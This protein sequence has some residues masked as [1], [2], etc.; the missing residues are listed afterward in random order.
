MNR[1]VLET[2]PVMSALI[3]NPLD[4]ED[5]MQLDAAVRSAHLKMIDVEEPDAG[6]AHDN[7]SKIA[8]IGRAGLSYEFIEALSCREEPVVKRRLDVPPKCRVIRFNDEM[9][10][11]ITWIFQYDMNVVVRLPLHAADPSED[12][13]DVEFLVAD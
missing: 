6:H 11:G 4:F 5:R 13:V 7:P 12:P 3:V 2:G 8:Q 10:R 1:D 9:L